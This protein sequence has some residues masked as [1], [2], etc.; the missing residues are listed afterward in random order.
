MEKMLE[1]ELFRRRGFRRYRCKVCGHYFWSL[2]ERDVCCDAPCMPYSFIGERIC[3][4]VPAS[5]SELRERYLRFFERHGHAR[6]RKYPVVAARWRQD[7]YLVGAS[8]YVFQP[9]VTEGIVPPPAN[10]LVISQPCIRLTDVD[11][12]GRS[13]RHLTGFEMMAH[14][15]FNYPDRH[16]Y[17]ID[18]TVELAHEFFTKELGIPEEEIV[19]KE[20]TWSGGGNAGECFE[21][22][23]RGLEVATLVFMHY[24]VTPDGKL[25]EMPMKIVDT[26]Y[27]LERIYWLCTGKP[28]VYEATF[29]KILTELRKLVGFEKPDDRLLAKLAITMSQM[30]SE[31]LSRPDI[32]TILADKLSLEPVQLRNIMLQQEFLYIVA[33][34]TRSLAWMIYDGVLP[35]NSG[36][37]YLARLLLRRML[38]YVHLLN[39]EIPLSE[40]CSKCA[41]FLVDEY[42][43]LKEIYNTLIEIS[44]ME[45]KKFR[46][47]LNTAKSQIMKIVKKGKKSVLS[48][49]DLV[50]L[51]DAYGVPPEIVE[52]ICKELNIGVE[53]PQNFYALLVEK[54]Q[55]EAAAQEGEGERGRKPITIDDVR[56]IAK[57][58]EIFYEDPYARE[59]RA[60]VLKVFE[61]DSKKYIVLDRTAFYPEGGGQPSDTG[62]IITE[63]GA[64]CKVVYVFKVGNVIVHEAECRGDVQEGEEVLGLVDW[65][66]RYSLMKMHTG[67]HILLQAIR[68]VLGAH[69][70]QAGVQKDIP[71]S[72]LDVTHYKVPSDEEIRKIEELANKI[73]ESDLP[74]ETEFLIRTEAEAKYGVRIYQGGFIP[75]PTLRIVKIVEPTGEIYD[76]QACAGTHV[77]KTSEVG[78]IKIVGVEKLQEGVI[79]FLFTTSRHVLEYLTLLERS[80]QDT[81]RVLGCSVSEV[82]DKVRKLVDS[83]KETESYVRRLEK[84]VSS[85]L[86]EQVS[87]NIVNVR[88]IAISFITVE[89]VSD[90]LVQDVARMFTKESKRILVV[91]NKRGDT[92]LEVKMF[93]SSDIAKLLSLR[94]IVREICSNIEECRGGGGG[95]FAQMNIRAKVNLDEIK[96]RILETIRSHVG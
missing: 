48:A 85:F 46:E 40:L 71:Y 82:P 75:S 62:R 68:R 27:G 73:I 23:V 95:T 6:V 26:G 8:I 90:R 83:L 36:I 57:T 77:K 87:K 65:D 56:G 53:I 44:D 19:Y 2:V 55:R 81:A 38:K 39:I 69:I 88:D 61:R 11:I 49:D 60:R 41:K 96:H 18:E 31:E 5:L 12:V 52:Q 1:T 42:P 34:H 14:H 86:M 13:G 80:L 63:R 9:W 15:A 50:M 29:D 67:T 64:E 10:P 24:K 54:K 17:W 7:V 72:R 33:D 22:L 89:D 92:G 76:V 84:L 79:R 47:T 28:N 74:V 66:R 4:T 51:Y 20:S 70:W 78:I 30:S 58:Q 37:G 94:D 21:V 32:Y 93:T 59:F 16:V 35:S 3:K 91:M 43:E 25:E 45:E